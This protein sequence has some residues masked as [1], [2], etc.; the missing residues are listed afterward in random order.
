MAIALAIVDGAS[1]YDSF[2][3][4]APNF[5]K[6]SDSPEVQ[7]IQNRERRA[8][9]RRDGEEDTVR[10]YRRPPALALGRR[11]MGQRPAGRVRCLSWRRRYRRLVADDADGE[12]V[13]RLLLPL[14]A[15][16]QCARHLAV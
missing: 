9:E 10:D 2:R 11:P 6:L 3:G 16:I 13:S 5:R 4:A 7:R 1:K 15:S 8:G 12:R 14:D